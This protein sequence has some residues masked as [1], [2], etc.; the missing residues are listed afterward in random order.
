MI[1]QAIGMMQQALPGL[2]PGT[3]VHKDVLKA[4]STI[5]RHIP[6]GAP[7]AGVQQNQLKDLLQSVVKNA[8]LSRIMGQQRAGPGPGPGG[9]AGPS[10]IAG[11]SATPPMPST[12][13]PGA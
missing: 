5:S 9:E 7:S 10:P 13:L 11:A 4:V 3:P 1:M 2:M 6:A 8:L 12:P